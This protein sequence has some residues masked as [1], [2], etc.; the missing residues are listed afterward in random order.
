M[1]K[2]MLARRSRILSLTLIQV[3]AFETMLKTHFATG[4]ILRVHICNQIE[5]SDSD[6]LADRSAASGMIR[7]HHFMQLKH[8]LV[9]G[10]RYDLN[11]GDR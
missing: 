5:G 2:S 10:H 9:G 1:V 11:C 6:G 3:M 8:V 7:M 4:N